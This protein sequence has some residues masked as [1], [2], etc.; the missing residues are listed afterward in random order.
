MLCNEGSQIGL[1]TGGV[2]LNVVSDYVALHALLVV[3]I[4]SLRSQVENRPKFSLK[5]PISDRTN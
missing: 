5:L 4:D 3:N 1:A 2:F